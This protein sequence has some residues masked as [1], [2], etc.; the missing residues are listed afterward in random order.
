[1]IEIPELKVEIPAGLF[2]IA[3]EE[4]EKSETKVLLREAVEEKLRVLLLF[5]VVDNILKKSK[6]TDEQAKELAEELE[7]KVAKRH[8]LI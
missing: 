8:G 5:K 2:K 1:M 7:E 6:L 3:G 4:L